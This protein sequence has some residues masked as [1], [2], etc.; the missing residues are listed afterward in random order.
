M[1]TG[2]WLRPT[3]FLMAAYVALMG[4]VTFGGARLWYGWDWSVF[5]Y[6]S[7][8]HA[9]A[10][11]SN[12]A[13]V[14]L[15]DYQ[16]GAPARDRQ[17]I[18]RFLDALR[19][20]GQPPAAVILDLSFDALCSSTEL[21][22][23]RPDAA[24]VAFTK[25]LDAAAAAKPR[26]DVYATENPLSPQGAGKI[27][28]G[29][30]KPLDRDN[31]YDHLA[32]GHTI[33]HLAPSDGLFY[34]RCYHFVEP[35]A[36][37]GGTRTRDLWA[38]PYRVV[39]A[40]AGE[41]AVPCA[42]SQADQ[43]LEA[44]RLGSHGDFVKSVRTVTLQHPFPAARFEGKYVIVATLAQD[45]GALHDAAEPRSNP[46]LLAWALSDQLD[47]KNV[48]AGYYQPLTPNEMVALLVIG[49]DLLTLVAF[50]AA[51]QGL[52]KTRLGEL[53]AHLP[54]IG[55]AAAATLSI[56]LFGALE[57]WMLFAKLIQPQ[58]SLVAVSILC[59]AGLCAERGR[60]ILRE[61]ASA[62]DAPPEDSNDYDV[63]ISYAHDEFSWVYENVFVP[64]KDARRR[65][66]QKL[67]IF[68]DTS[69]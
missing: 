19:A 50:V 12:I 17:T 31:V 20:H 8:L 29:S 35:D 11:A 52:R 26:I 59:S 2:P 45:V 68:F 3:V 40:A 27:D 44:V 14:D 39:K 58:V 57:A 56:V 63:F 42:E 18:A 25:S 13:V 65:D 61:Q 23:C 53:R 15:A 5:Q 32:S 21:Q 33:M 22:R 69:S 10:F 30:L 55:A 6:L 51:F 47:R 9:P 16:V 1:I 64:F 24:T 4:A 67:A 48:D 54:W 7:D 38:L 37:G 62:V 60:Q 66:G 34:Q 36:K 49:F 41:R 46:E 43:T 28:Q